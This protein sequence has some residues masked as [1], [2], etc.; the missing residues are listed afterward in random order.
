MQF[1]EE[2]DLDM[3]SFSRKAASAKPPPT[4][5]QKT[6]MD[7]VEEVRDEDG[8]V[9]ETAKEVIEVDERERTIR[10]LMKVMS[11]QIE[12]IEEQAKKIEQANKKSEKEAEEYLKQLAIAKQ[13]RKQH[14]LK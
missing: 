6:R 13:E 2:D 7:K 14:E 9:V 1:M 3:E 11:Y 10:C 4:A 12:G 5:Y 8:Q